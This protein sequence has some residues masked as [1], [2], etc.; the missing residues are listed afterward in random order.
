M[1]RFIKQFFLLLREG[2]KTKVTEP[3]CRKGNPG[4]IYGP[5]QY[6]MRYFLNIATRPVAPMAVPRGIALRSI[7]K[8]E[9]WLLKGKV[10][11]SFTAFINTVGFEMPTSIK[12]YTLLLLWGLP[13]MRVQDWHADL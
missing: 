10:S 11:P 8:L 7:S 13:G 5:I 2:G 9:L 4:H 6:V 12:S 3:A 1:F